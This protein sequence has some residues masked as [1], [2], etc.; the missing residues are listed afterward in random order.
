MCTA[1]F[2]WQ[3]GIPVNTLASADTDSVGLEWSPTGTDPWQK[4][5]DNLYPVNESQVFT[6]NPETD[7]YFRAYSWSNYV[8]R[9]AVTMKKQF[10][11]ITSRHRSN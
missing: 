2:M 5:G 4:F 1:I 8:G 11:T 7:Y 6:L 3:P 10:S 9:G